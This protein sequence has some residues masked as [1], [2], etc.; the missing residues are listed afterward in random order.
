MWQEVEEESCYPSSENKGA[1]QLVFAYAD[2]WFSAAAAHIV[3]V[4]YGQNLC[5]NINVGL[6]YM[7]VNS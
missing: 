6:L 5:E 3:Y 4:Y 2:C 1:D 7:P